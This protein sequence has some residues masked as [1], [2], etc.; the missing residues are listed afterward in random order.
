[1]LGNIKGDAF[2]ISLA[3]KSWMLPDTD[4]IFRVKGISSLMPPVALVIDSI[5]QER[6]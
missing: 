4:S 3:L 5:A 2:T 1:M 6:G